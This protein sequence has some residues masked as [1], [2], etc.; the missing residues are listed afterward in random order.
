VANAALV[1]DA[2]R[3]L[4]AAEALLADEPADDVDGLTTE[5][6]CG[7]CET[8]VEAGRVAHAAEIAGLTPEQLVQRCEALIRESRR[9]GN[10]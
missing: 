7:R 5:Q 1:K 10:A 6:L 4:A 2:H 8:K 9:P 3:L